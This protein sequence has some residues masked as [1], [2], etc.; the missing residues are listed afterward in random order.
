MMSTSSAEARTGQR[1]LL[2]LLAAMAMLVAACGD[3]DS[4]TDAASSGSSSGSA[5]G[6]GSA[7]A[8]ADEDG[9]DGADE[10]AA[11]PVTLT[12]KY[13]EITIEA[14]PMRVVSV[15]FSDQ[16]DLLALGVTPVGIRDWYGEQPFGI[17]PWA[18]DELGDAEPDVLSASEINFEAVAALQPDLIVGVSSGM[19]DEDYETLSQI[20]PTLAQSGDYV[21]Y[22]V[23]WQDRTRVIGEALGKADDAEAIVAE[24]ED[25][26]A[27]IRDA[28]PDFADSTAA[29]AFFF[30]EEPGAYAS[31]DTRARIM[32]D[33]GFVTPEVYDEMAAD[34]F[35]ASFSAE[36]IE[37]LD[38]D[39]LVWLAASDAEIEALADF[40]LRNNLRATQEGRE[41][42]VG[43]L[44]GGAFSFAS[45]LSLDYLLDELVPELAAAVDGDP[46][47]EVPSAAA[48]G[49]AATG[50]GGGD[51]GAEPTE[52]EAAAMAAWALVF[53]STAAFA[54]KAP[55]L[56]DA[57]ALET[58]NVGFLDAGDAMGGISLDPTGAVVD[59]E[60]A[61]IT[62]DVYF[63]ENAAY[64]DLDGEISLVDGVWVVSRDEYCGFLASARTPCEG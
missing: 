54:D 55:H 3:G 31:T 38:V 40:E 10:T 15:G 58:S 19:T 4:T 52:E 7:S 2:A 27:E 5:S 51:D 56:E 1:R 30:G 59:G 41:V 32:E 43:Q 50:A 33:L 18:Q 21:D 24:I 48:L 8:P 13:G 17:W 46:A 37:L 45:P 26:F 44:L 9:T 29:V 12:H 23:P 62:Y 49:A 20:A 25:R 64:N 57:A 39:T 11:F 60:T 34:A 47:T 6:S 53:D 63:G 16:D 28:N 22:G 42:F 61:T 35:Y 36:E 14:E